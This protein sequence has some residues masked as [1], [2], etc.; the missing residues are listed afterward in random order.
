[1][2]TNRFWW[3]EEEEEEGEREEGKKKATPRRAY[4]IGCD[5]SENTTSGHKLQV[6]R[7]HLTTSFPLC[8]TVF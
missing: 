6:R 2:D 1:M 7:Y 8:V 3:E 5:H 4:V